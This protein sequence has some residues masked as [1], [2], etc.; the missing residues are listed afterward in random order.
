MKS[1]PDLEAL[2]QLSGKIT[3]MEQQQKDP[4]RRSIFVDGEFVLG[5]H[6]ETV[7]LAKLRVGQTVDGTKLVEV[8][9][10]D[11]AKRAWDDALG[12]LSACARSRREVERKLARRYPPEVA[13]GVVERLAN[14]G[15]L[16]DA[17]F[18]AVYVRSHAAYGERRLLT[19]L[20][21]KGVARETA[22]RVV[23]E[24]VGAVDAVEQAREAAQARFARM[25]GADRDTAQRRLSGF[26]ARRGYDFETISRALAPL[27]ADL[28]R[29]RK[30]R[31]WGRR[32]E[33]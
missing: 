10:R 8:L 14:G 25:A 18:A 5:L 28:P 27:L 30:T 32:E 20:A 2:A 31:T 24:L 1:A 19:D 29:V 7:I 13:A 22:A 26:L 6:E 33:E 11:E 15:W 12:F 21:R 17:E 16:D 9:R 4:K 23:K 3:A